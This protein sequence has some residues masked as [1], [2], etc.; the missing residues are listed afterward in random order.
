[1]TQ[2][3]STQRGS[4][5]AELMAPLRL[6]LDFRRLL[7][8]SW[9]SNLGDGAAI[10]AGPLLV[11][12]QTHAPFL[13]ASAALLQRL[14]WLLFGLHAGVLAD[15]LDRRLVVAFSDLMRAAVLAVLAI[16]I[17]TGWVNIA[18][19]LVAMFLIGVTEVFSTTTS[20]T[21]L[22]MLVS[23]SD[24]GSANARL[25]SSVVFGN[26]LIGPLVGAMLFA[27]G[28]AVPFV[29]QAV[30][31]GFA[32]ILVLRIAV[33]RQVGRLGERQPARREIVEGIRWLL[34]H[35]AMR[36]LALVIL[37]F[38]VT[39]GAAWS[40]LV[41]WSDE[42][43]HAGAFGFGML[44]AATAVGGLC[45]AAS[46]GWLDRNVSYE[47][48]MKV[49]LSLEVLLHLALAFTTT[50]WVALILMAIFGCYAFVWGAVSQT[51]RQRAVPEEFQGRVASVY[52]IGSFGGI[53]LGQAIGGVIAAQWGVVAPFWFAFVGTGIILVAI[54]P[55][56]GRV[57]SVP[58]PEAG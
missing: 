38:N 3:P 34:G 56:L 11:A 49:C 42:R 8:A 6:G 33:R 45:A 10:A 58:R 44:T 41:L 28:H 13:V 17:A 53:V 35:P 32:A 43:L 47:R 26:Q 27:L 31:V 55:Q 24:L 18:V 57:V 22:P 7:A 51:I 39:F 29:A 37:T 25:Q 1:M 52:L 21:L 4:R 2:A 23:S 5:V 36:T 16:A 50:I 54:W 14:P 46:F 30:F 20:A 48:L 15:R 12:S 9:I 40:V 19:V